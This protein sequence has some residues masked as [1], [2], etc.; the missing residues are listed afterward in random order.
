MSGYL[1]LCH[2]TCFKQALCLFGVLFTHPFVC[3]FVCVSFSVHASL[4]PCVCA[5]FLTCVFAAVDLCVTCV[6]LLLVVFVWLVVVLF[7]FGWCADIGFSQSV[8][9][10]CQSQSVYM[11]WLAG[12]LLHALL[13]SLPYLSHCCCTVVVQ[14]LFI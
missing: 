11:L 5:V 3:P 7:V 10:L 8:S 9:W 14:L 13:P 4:A 12:C 2:I 1:L 6:S